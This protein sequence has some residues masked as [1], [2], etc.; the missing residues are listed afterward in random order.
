MVDIYGFKV[1]VYFLESGGRVWAYGWHYE[2][3]RALNHLKKIQKFHSLKGEIVQ[4]DDLERWLSRELKSVVE[5]GRQFSIP[6]FPYKHRAVYESLVRIPRGKTATY[7]EI[8]RAAGVKFH[9]MLVALMRN[10]FQILIPCHR[11][12]TRKG[13]LMGFYPLGIQVKETLLRIEGAIRDS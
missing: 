10:P 4:S 3:E 9:E 6:D 5:D 1:H 12:I 2:R 13:T 8:S 7:P 11:L